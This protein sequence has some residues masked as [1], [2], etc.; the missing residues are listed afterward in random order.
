MQHFKDMN[1]QTIQQKKIV[2]KGRPGCF[3][4]IEQAGVFSAKM[5]ANRASPVKYLTKNE[6][7]A[8]KAM[9]TNRSNR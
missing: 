2:R 8:M 6:K 9:T 4:K 3:R 7:M 5:P 1:K